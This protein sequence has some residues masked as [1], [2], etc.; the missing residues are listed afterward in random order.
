M[1]QCVTSSESDSDESNYSADGDISFSSN[2]VLLNESHDD[3]LTIKT[4]SANSSGIK[5]ASVTSSSRS[6][7]DVLKAP[8]ASDLSTKRSVARNP[9]CGKKKSRPRTASFDPANIKSSQR[10]KEYQ[11]KPFTVSNCA[12]FCKGCSRN[13]LYKIIW[14]H[15]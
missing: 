8:T 3:D 10:M 4:R 14:K 9:P 13:D 11:N 15:Q 6:L 12:L 7:L 2:S 5:T 1:R